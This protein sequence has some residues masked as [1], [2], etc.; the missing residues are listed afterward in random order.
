MSNEVL[1]LKLDQARG[2]R[3]GIEF[4]MARD[5]QRDRKSVV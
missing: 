3:N 2:E 1:I 5:I 4:W